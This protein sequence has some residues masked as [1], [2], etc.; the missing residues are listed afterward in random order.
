MRV[1]IL[2]FDGCPHADIAGTRVFEA[3]RLESVRAV[4]ER[5]NVDTPESAHAWRFLGSPSI[6]VDGTDVEPG[7][8][9]RGEHGLACRTY[10][11]NG[12]VSGAPPVDMI[13]KAIRTRLGRE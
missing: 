2:T 11:Q 8:D 6:R 7:A 12:T 10:R 4:V 9:R 3:L 5:V 1:E 13:R